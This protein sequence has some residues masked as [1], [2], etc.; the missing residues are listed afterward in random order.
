MI[1]VDVRGESAGLTADDD[2]M[3]LAVWNE[4]NESGIGYVSLA[5]PDLKVTMIA[6]TRLAEEN[7]VLSPDNRFVAYET[8]ET[9]RREI[10][11]RTFPDG[12]GHWQVSQDGGAFPF[13][14]PDGKHLYFSSL[15]N[16]GLNIVD[17]SRDPDHISAPRRHIETDMMRELSA[18]PDGGFVTLVASAGQARARYE[19]WLNWGA[20]NH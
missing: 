19:V 2:T 7:P 1:A 18:L 14:S 20:Q 4:A 11:V 8:V 5:D 12:T 16:S 3:V 6:D 15:S 9:G 13:W 17:V 10:V